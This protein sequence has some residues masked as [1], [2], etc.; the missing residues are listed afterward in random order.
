MSVRAKFKVDAVESSLWTK[1]IDPKGGYGPENMKKVEMKTIK[2]SPVSY[3]ADNNENSAFWDASP[4]GAM[5]LGCI[6]PEASSQFELGGEY[7]I[8]FTKAE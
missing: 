6:N 4:N 2:M 3:S 5:Q 1:Q 8:D 7:Y